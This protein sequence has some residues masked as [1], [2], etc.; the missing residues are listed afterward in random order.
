MQKHFVFIL[1]ILLALSVSQCA[2]RG[3]PTGGSKDSIPPVLIKANPPLNSTMFDRNKITLEFDEYIKLKDI[4]KQ[5]ITSPPLEPS[6]YK[7]SPES[8]VSKKVE[9]EFLDSLKPNITYTFNFGS[10]TPQA[11]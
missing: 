11:V 7:I 10:A 5:L 6:Q 3:I 4:T 1:G 8:T 2:K 9:I